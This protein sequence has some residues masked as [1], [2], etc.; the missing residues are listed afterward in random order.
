LLHLL[1]LYASEGCEPCVTLV[2]YYNR[3]AGRALELGLERLTVARFDVWRHQARPTSP[4][5]RPPTSPDLCPHLC[6][7]LA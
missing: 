2:M 7:R 3:L 4:R 1:Q 6:P 5:P